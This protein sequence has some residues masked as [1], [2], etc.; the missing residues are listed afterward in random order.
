VATIKALVAADI[1]PGK[2][3]SHMLADLMKQ[4]GSMSKGRAAVHTVAARHYGTTNTP[5]V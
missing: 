4:V 3:L 1:Q 5:S 2:Q